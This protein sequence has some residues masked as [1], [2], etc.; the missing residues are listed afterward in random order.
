LRILHTEAAHALQRLHA[1]GV[2]DE[3]AIRRAAAGAGILRAPRIILRSGGASH[4]G[5]GD[6]H[7]ECERQMSHDNLPVE[8]VLSLLTPVQ[9][10]L[11]HGLDR[12]PRRTENSIQNRSNFR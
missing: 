10:A 7:P 8:R 9:P 12:L 1:L 5:R 4:R 11:F 6:K 3:P 2:A